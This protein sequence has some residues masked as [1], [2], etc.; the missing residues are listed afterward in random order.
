MI[1]KPNR[2][3]KQDYD[4]MFKKKPETANLYLLLCEL[5]D[6]KGR[7][8]SNEQELADLMEARF[9]DPGEYALRGETSG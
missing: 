7:V 6:K 1:F 3:F 4:Q 9:N 2:K 5:S 8:V